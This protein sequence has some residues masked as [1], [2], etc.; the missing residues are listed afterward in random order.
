VSSP[1]R[2]SERAG[3]RR[4]PG[5]HRH[6]LLASVLGAAAR[7]VPV[8]IDGF[9]VGAATLIA[10][11]FAPTATPYLIASHRSVARGHRA[12]SGHLDLQ[13]LR[14]LTMRL[15][16]GTGAVL[17]LSIGQAACTIL[18]EMAPCAEA[19]VSEGEQQSKEQCISNGGR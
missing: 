11:T 12:V 4:R 16:E 5:G 10:A 14:D 3:E 15:G 7:R 18:D 9:H 1:T 13:P 2:W 8:I 19:G 17:A 6:S